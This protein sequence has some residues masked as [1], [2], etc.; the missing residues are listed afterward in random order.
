MTI[1][2]P[3][4]YQNVN[5]KKKL[6]AKSARWAV[7]VIALGLVLTLLWASTLIWLVFQLLSS[8]TELFGLKFSLAL[9]LVPA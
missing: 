4:Q 8:P 3:A 9:A 7:A 6:A 2:D 5:L 1:S